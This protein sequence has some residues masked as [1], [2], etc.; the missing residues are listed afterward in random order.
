M[1]DSL[2]QRLLRGELVLSGS[3]FAGSHSFPWKGIW[4]T[5]APPRVTFFAWTAAS[6]KIPT[7][8][9]L[10]R[11]GMIVVN[12]C[13]LCELDGESMDHLLLHCGVANALWSAIFGRFGL[14][15]VMPCSI[16]ELFACWWSCGR[17]RSVVV[18]KMIP[19]SYVVYLEGT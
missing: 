8:G 3:F 16:R 12:R 1:V 11:R 13:W 10:R 4:R 6:N 9:N 15:W 5:K 17:S 18:W 7:I 19:L 2:K 14:C